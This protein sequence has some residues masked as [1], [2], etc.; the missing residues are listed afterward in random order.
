MSGRRTVLIG[1]AFITLIGFAARSSFG[2]APRQRLDYALLSAARKGDMTKIKP[3]LVKGANPNAHDGHGNTPL[4]LLLQNERYTGRHVSAPVTTFHSDGTATAT[5]EETYDNA[6]AASTPDTDAVKALLSRGAN[7][8]AANHGGT[9]PLMIAASHQ[10][11][12]CV[13]LLL[14]HGADIHANTA[15][16]SNVLFWAVG[17]GHT[18]MLA[19]L[20]KKGLN[21]NI[22]RKLD[23]VTP[24]MLEVTGGNV[25]SVKLLLDHGANIHAVDKRGGTALQYAK[26]A[27]N[28]P[29]VK[30][31]MPRTH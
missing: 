19:L 11:L 21:P 4:L 1:M 9:T 16:G 28:T 24:L 29:V 18:Q 10:T 30:L 15:D 3:L 12:D 2:S 8:N 7:V 20:L 14:S 26:E 31:L 27:H 13:N 22:T 5:F 23:G 25:N 17:F 6:V